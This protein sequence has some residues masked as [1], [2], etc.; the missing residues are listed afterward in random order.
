MGIRT[1]ELYIANGMDYDGY[2]EPEI[3]SDEI[4]PDYIAAE[5]SDTVEQLQSIQGYNTATF[6]FITDMHYAAKFKYTHLIRLRRT[7]NAYKKISETAQSDFLVM[8]GDHITNGSKSYV[9]D[10]FRALRS[11]L[12]GIRYMP[13]NGNHDDNCIWDPVCIKEQRAINHLLPEERYTLFYN[14][15]PQNGAV[16]NRQNRGLY[17]YADNKDMRVRYIFLDTGDVPYKY[18]ENGALVY[19]T[20]NFYAF[21]QAQLDWLVNEALSFEE[22]GW[23]VMVFQHVP[24][25]NM[26][27]ET[28]EDL[29]RISVIHDILKSRNNGTDLHINCGTGDFCIKLN[30]EFSKYKSCD[31]AAVMCGHIHCDD[32]KK[33]DGI[34]YISTA[35]SVMY[36]REK[37]PLNRFDG[38]KNELLFDMATINKKERTLSLIRVGAGADRKFSY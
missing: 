2:L 16:F 14:H 9:S 23:T 1:K 12:S 10:C 6:G 33:I 22:D 35:N 26:S 29:S 27:F 36:V 3:T 17:Y 28:R 21:S 13:V 5:V 32:E 11:E 38:T 15:A 24:P 4:Y 37:N 7:L 20:H 30:A 34:Q 18:D 19:F 31:I 25:M 8:G